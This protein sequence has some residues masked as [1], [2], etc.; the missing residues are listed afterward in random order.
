[1]KK[2]K[3]CF[4]VL[5]F[6]LLLGTAATFACSTECQAN[7]EGDYSFFIVHSDECEWR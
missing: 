5:V 2:L 1:M 6:G 7:N 4:V 3:R